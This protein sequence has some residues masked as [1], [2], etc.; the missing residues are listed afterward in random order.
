MRI[1]NFVLCNGVAWVLVPVDASKAGLAKVCSIF[2]E[3]VYLL[4]AVLELGQ[5]RALENQDTQ[6]SAQHEGKVGS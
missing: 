3:F 5:K 4:G 2:E 6:I 1:A